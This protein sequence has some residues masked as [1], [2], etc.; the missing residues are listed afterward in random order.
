VN[1]V[2]WYVRNGELTRVGNM[3]QG[4]S[5]AVVDV[6]VPKGIDVDA[7]QQR[8]LAVATAVL[9]DPQW[10]QSV[11]EKPELWGLESVTADGVVLRLVVR[12]RTNTKDDVAWSLRTHLREA[13]VAAGVEPTAISSAPLPSFE[14]A[15]ALRGV[16][17]L[18]WNPPSAR[19][20]RAR[21]ARPAEETPPAPAEPLPGAIAPSV[22]RTR[23]RAGARGASG[24][25][26]AVG[27]QGAAGPDDVGDVR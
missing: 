20:P 17:P 26:G 3:S 22:P 19:R 10:R 14:Q 24:Q 7:V 25:P 1:G 11:M 6:T 4:W 16:R 8:L 2:L 9:D 23:P 18:S 15:G 12:T 5:R 13:L 27:R 21:A